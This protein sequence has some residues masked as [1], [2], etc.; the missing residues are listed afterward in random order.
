MVLQAGCYLLSL[1]WPVE[2]VRVGKVGGNGWHTQEPEGEPAEHLIG[3]GRLDLQQLYCHD[4]EYT[5]DTFV[6]LCR[7]ETEIKEA[8]ASS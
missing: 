8:Q 1:R 6:F 2:S 3:T 4:L 5:P 7:V